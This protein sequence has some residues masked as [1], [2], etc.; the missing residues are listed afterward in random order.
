M[1]MIFSSED[2]EKQITVLF[3]LVVILFIV[4]LFLSASVYELATNLETCGTKLE[5]LKDY[6]G[7]KNS[8]LNIKDRYNFLY[9]FSDEVNLT[10]SEIETIVQG[11]YTNNNS[12]GKEDGD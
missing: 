6:D 4:N 12:E 8:G 2:K 7:F 1:K 3:V 11:N 5:Q 9:N 10:K